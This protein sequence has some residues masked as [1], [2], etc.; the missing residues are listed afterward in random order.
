VANGDATNTAD[1]LRISLNESVPSINSGSLHRQTFHEQLT[2]ASLRGGQGV[3]GGSF[4]ITDSQGRAGAVNLSVSGAQTVGDVLDLING[5]NIGVEATINDTGDGILLADTA[6]GLDTLTVTDVGNG[7]AA[8]N[9]RIAGTAVTVDRNGNPTQVIDGTTTLRIKLDDDDTLQDLA[10]K[11]NAENGGIAASLFYT[12]SGTSPYRLALVSQ[13][14]GSAGEMLVDAHTLGISLQEVVAAKDALMLTGT[15]DASIGGA[16]TSSS[17]NDFDHLIEGVRLTVNNAS[18]TEVTV[19]VRQTDDAIVKQLDLFV[20]Q[21]NKLRGKL[22][23]LTYFNENDKTTGA[24]FGSA[25][26]LRIDVDLAQVVTSRYFGAGPIRSLEEL[27][28]SLDDQGKLRFDKTEFHAAYTRDP[29]AV[30]Q[31][32]TQ[33]DWGVAA[34]L[35]RVTQQLAGEGNSVLL[36]RIDALQWTID[37]NQRRT[38]DLNAMLERQSELLYKEFYNLETV[39]GKLQN[40]MTAL[41]NIQPLAPLVSTRK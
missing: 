8:R 36:N 30:E 35:T 13:T 31:F 27:G 5:L 3:G 7:T 2:L 22:D 20:E 28:L 12:G 23:E 32:F 38:A 25:E 17:S 6:G 4:L 29:Q 21:Y 34:K 41:S 16:L 24:L 33:G 40:S 26:A 9:L 39:I 10:D 15:G 11:I 18:S 19:Q 1:K 37:A 14:T